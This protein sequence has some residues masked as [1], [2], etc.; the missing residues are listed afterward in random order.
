MRTR[1]QTRAEAAE[2]ST[3][4]TP[5]PTTSSSSPFT[6]VTITKNEGPIV[7]LSRKRGGDGASSGGLGAFGEVRSKLPPP[8]QF[9]LVAVL[10]LS[11]ATLGYSLTWRYSKAPL[12]P[13]ARILSTW[14]DFGTLVGWRIFE[15]ALAWYG[16]YDGYDITAL[17]I[18]SNGPLLYLLYSF[19]SSPPSALLLTLTIETLATYIPFR[20]LRP[21]SVAHA[22]PSHAP[23]AEITT[24]RPIALLT[25]L[26]AGAIYSVSLFFAYATYLPNYLVVY[27]ANLP[28]IE[29]AHAVTY[30]NFLPVTLVL[31]FAARAF[32]FA[33]PAVP[34]SEGPHHNIKTEKEGYENGSAEVVKFD[35]VKA[36]LAETIRWNFWGWSAQTKVVIRRSALLCFV[37]GVD[38]YLQTRLT[39]DGVESAGAVAWSS[40]WVLAAAVTGLALGVVGSV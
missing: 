2:E 24:D 10:S 33:P 40:V 8:I 25:T 34:T 29:A 36:T 26:L 16:N 12:V 5:P 30:I 9:P 14:T 23:N 4:I 20:L 1:K 13:H 21:L 22:D 11:L 35:P 17:N 19:Y 32:I 28:S 3:D 18:L 37:A 7:S 31:G 6:V 39:I 15:L 27:F 38:T